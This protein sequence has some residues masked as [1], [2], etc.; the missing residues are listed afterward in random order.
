MGRHPELRV[1]TSV[2]LGYTIRTY[3]FLVLPGHQHQAT[4]SVCDSN[5]QTPS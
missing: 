3:K 5:I 1:L 2:M 4:C